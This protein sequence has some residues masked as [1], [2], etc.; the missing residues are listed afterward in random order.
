M[1]GF[2]NNWLRLDHD[3]IW[4]PYTSMSNPLP[5]YPVA[6]AEGVRIR[7]ADG[8]ELIDGMSSWW[9]AIHG[10]NHPELN[11]A[12]KAQLDSMAHVMFGGLTH[13]PAVELAGELLALAPHAIDRIFFA[14]SGSVAVEVAIKMAIQYWHA[15]GKPGKSKLLTI[16]SGYHGDTFGAMSVCDPVTGMHELFTGV[17]PKH[18]FAPAPKSKFDEPLAPSDIEPVARLLEQ[19]HQEIAAMIIEPVVQGAG[20]MRIY[21]PQFVTEARRLC[22]EHGVL[23]I[24]D[25]IATAFG[26]TGRMFASEHAGIEPDI[27]CVG[28]ALTGGYLTLAATM[29]TPKVAD[30]ISSGNPGV[31]MHGPTFMA[32]PLACAIALA[33][34]RVLNGSDWKTRVSQI[35][36]QMKR[37]LAHCRDLAGVV[38]VRALGAIGVVEMAEPV[39]VGTLQK[40]FVER[41]VWVRP[42]GTQVYI[43][44]PYIIGSEDLTRLTGAIHDVLANDS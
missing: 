37:E 40:A 2:D 35:E 26:R 20:G 44:P 1:K 36:A 30:V 4:H 15:L 21:S 38:D 42:F 34:L 43:M 29:T 13:Q 3:K 5:V 25:E 39:D 7:L 12:A 27:V 41:G 28:K 18:F 8:T 6:S 17:L 32:N 9:A 11:A 10:Y 33:S 19:H 23:L 22:D 16:R 31:F 24:L 14:D